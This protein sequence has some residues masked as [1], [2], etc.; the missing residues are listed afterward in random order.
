MGDGRQHNHATVGGNTLS[1]ELLDDSHLLLSALC[2]FQTSIQQRQI[3]M[4][5]RF[6]RIEFDRDFQ[7]LPR[8]LRDVRKAVESA[9]R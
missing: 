4:R 1:L 9:S 2:I 3:V 5:R 6:V 8:T 7:L